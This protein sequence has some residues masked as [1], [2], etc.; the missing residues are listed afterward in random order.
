MGGNSACAAAWVWNR[1]TVGANFS[2]LTCK[3]DGSKSY[4]S[5]EV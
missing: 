2:A 3:D 1:L 5:A 4:V